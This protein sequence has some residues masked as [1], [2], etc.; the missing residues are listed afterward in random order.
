MKT[1]KIHLRKKAKTQP[2]RATTYFLKRMRYNN[3]PAAKMETLYKT[4]LVDTNN[5][6]HYLTPDKIDKTLID[7]GLQLREKTEQTFKL[8][9]I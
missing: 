3:A 9:L 8:R 5:V 6:P 7:C 1:T 4:F 2:D